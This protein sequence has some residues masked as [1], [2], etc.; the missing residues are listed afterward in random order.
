MSWQDIPGWSNDIVPFY[1]QLARELPKGGRFVEVGVFMGRSLA[2]MGTL[3]TDLDLWAVD[4]WV[5][6]EAHEHAAYRD[7]Y[8]SVWAAFTRGMN[9]HAPEVYRRLHVLRARSTDVRIPGCDAVFIDAGHDYEDIAADLVHWAPQIVTGGILCGHD[10][11]HNDVRRAVTECFGHPNIGPDTD[12]TF[13]EVDGRQ[14][15]STCWW[16]RIGEKT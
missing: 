11:G 2:C 16:T 12:G 9:D 3:R 7:S 13:W 4:P 8:G 14:Y 10:F 6:E 1:E 15:R 5:E